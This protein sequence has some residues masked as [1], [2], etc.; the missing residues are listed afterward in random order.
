MLGT[1]V[2][3]STILAGSL[4]GSVF[5]RGI[6]ENYKKALFDALGLATVGLGANAVVSNMPHSKFPVLFILSWLS[7]ACLVRRWISTDVSKGWPDA[8]K[9]A[10]TWGRV[11][12]RRSCCSASVLYLFWVLSKVRCTAIIPIFLLMRHLILSLRWYWL[13]LM[14]SVSAWLAWYCSFGRDPFICLPAGWHPF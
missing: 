10:L 1:I 12:R 9:A 14:A 8:L 5:G 11:W 6:K 7:A 2:N 4:L 3:T 13:R